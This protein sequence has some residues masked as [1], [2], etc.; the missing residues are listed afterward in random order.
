MNSGYTTIL[1]LV[2]KVFGS[3]LQL[4]NLINLS[5][6]GYILTNSRDAPAHMHRHMNAYMLGTDLCY[7]GIKL[8]SLTSI[9]GDNSLHIPSL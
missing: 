1:P 2:Y 8:A 5:R 3:S 4:Y 6:E 9:G 7:V